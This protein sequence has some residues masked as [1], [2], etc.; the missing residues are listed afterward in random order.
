VRTT[1]TASD[2]GTGR[3][4]DVLLEL[5]PHDVV[6]SWTSRCVD[7]SRTPAQACGCPVLH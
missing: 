4:V 7:C 6:A 5:S 3:C 2:A 1:L